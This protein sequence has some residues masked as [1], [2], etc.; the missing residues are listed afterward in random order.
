MDRDILQ[1]QL[2]TIR[3]KGGISGVGVPFR[4]YKNAL[5]TRFTFDKYAMP[6]KTAR[7]EPHFVSVGKKENLVIHESALLKLPELLIGKNDDLFH[8]KTVLSLRYRPQ[9]L[10]PI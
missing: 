6:A 1:A 2:S 7:I 10:L 9:W 4:V 3:G 5:F 8:L